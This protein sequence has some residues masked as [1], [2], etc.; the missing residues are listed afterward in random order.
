MRIT[1]GFTAQLP[2]RS[3]LFFQRDFL[4]AYET[5]GQ[6]SGPPPFPR[7]MGIITIQAP[8]QQAI[9][10]KAVRFTAY[11][12]SGIGVD[13][14]EEVP[15]G[16]TVGTL[17]FSF[18]VG[19]RGLTDYT[20]NLPG[21]SG[22]PYQWGASNVGNMGSIAPIAGQGNL[23]QGTGP[24]TPLDAQP[25]FAAYARPGDLIQ[26]EAVVFRP[27]NFELK[28]VQVQISGWL[29]AEEELDNIVDANDRGGC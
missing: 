24:A 25:N 23:I 14:L 20:T 4:R 9:V 3:R 17:G 22:T 16:R 29:A 10:I 12:R 5:P 28:V 6:V 26:A 13:G 8:Q 2:G 18:R 21:S 15:R 7:T 27:P 11:E 19:N 1:H